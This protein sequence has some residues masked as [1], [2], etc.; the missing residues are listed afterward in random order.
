MHDL[1]GSVQTNFTCHTDGR[2]FWSN[3]AKEVKIIKIKWYPSRYPED[4]DEKKEG[5]PYEPEFLVRVYFDP[6]AWDIK[7]YGLIYTDEM[8]RKTLEE[9]VVKLAGNNVLPKNMPW[10]EIDYTEQGMQGED[11]VHMIL[12]V[13]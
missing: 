8:F 9:R 12:G 1:E 2:G 13:W 11:H 10:K 7:K 6:R 3:I 4:Y 5:K